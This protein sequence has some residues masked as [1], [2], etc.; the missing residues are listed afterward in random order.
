[1]D[2]LNLTD[3]FSALGLSSKVTEAVTAAGY[4]KPTEI[5]APGTPHVLEMKDFIGIAL[6]GTGKTS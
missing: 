4:T 3:D 5:L 2:R 1:V 6:T